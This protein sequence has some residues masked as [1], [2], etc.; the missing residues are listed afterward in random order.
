MQAYAN[1]ANPVTEGTLGSR[2]F[3]SKYVDVIHEDLYIKLD[4]DFA[5]ASFNV[6][7]FIQ[8]SIDGIQ[9]PFL[10]VASKYLDSFTIT[11][12]GKEV[13]IQDIPDEFKVPKKTK[14]K[15]FSYFFEPESYN[16]DPYV[17]FYTSSKGGDVIDLNDMIYFETDITKGRHLIEVNYRATKWSNKLPHGY[18]YS[19]RYALSPAKYWKSFG[20]L[21]IKVDA[22]DCNKNLTTNLGKPQKGN[23]RLLAEWDFD[24]L[25]VEILQINF[26]RYNSSVQPDQYKSLIGLIFIIGGFLVILFLLILFFFR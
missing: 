7:Y 19:F 9:I 8:S 1:M 14:F 23:L 17:I 18:E 10:F 5:F 15:D 20:T 13:S 4:K 24:H 16:D 22:S 11:I 12:D 3:V 21:N 26:M 25:P 6:K 2:P